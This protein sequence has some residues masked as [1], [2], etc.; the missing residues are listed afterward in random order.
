M[1]DLRSLLE[2]FLGTQ[3]TAEALNALPTSA[4]IRWGPLSTADPALVTYAETLLAGAIGSA[5]ARVMVASVVKEEPL[6]LGEVMNI[7][8]ETRQVIAYSRELE[9]AHGGAQIREPAPA[10]ARPPQKRVHLHRHP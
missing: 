8:D 1:T 7:L 5:S 2:R 9:R 3:R 4:N 6:G 10:G